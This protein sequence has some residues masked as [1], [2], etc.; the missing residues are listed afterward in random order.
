M[1]QSGLDAGYSILDS[2]RS[3]EICFG[4]KKKQNHYRIPLSPLYMVITSQGWYGPVEPFPW[5]RPNPSQI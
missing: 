5:S 1:K 4:E 2:V 3:Q